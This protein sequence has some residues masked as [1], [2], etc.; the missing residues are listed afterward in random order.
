M[1]SKSFLLESSQLAV[2]F[3]RFLGRLME[4]EMLT[5]IF[6]KLIHGLGVDVSGGFAERRGNRE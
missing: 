6:N 3:V 5:I 4:S 1:E 2:S